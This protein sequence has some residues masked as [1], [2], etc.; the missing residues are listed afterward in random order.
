MIPYEPPE[1]GRFTLRLE[2]GLR[3]LLAAAA[4][5]EMRSLCAEIKIRLRRSLDGR[6]QARPRAYEAAER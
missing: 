4:Q 6:R 3:A 5:Q 1:D 2:P